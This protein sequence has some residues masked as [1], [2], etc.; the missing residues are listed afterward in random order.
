MGFNKFV[1][2]FQVRALNVLGLS[3]ETLGECLR[4]SDLRFSYVLSEEEEIRC[5][6]EDNQ[7]NQ[8]CLRGQEKK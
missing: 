4:L 7:I 3:V 6:S 1:F 2:T 5:L 8:R